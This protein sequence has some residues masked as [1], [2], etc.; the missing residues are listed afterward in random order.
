MK[1]APSCLCLGLSI[2]CLISVRSTYAAEVD[3]KKLPLPAPRKVDFVKDI[4]PIFDEKCISCHGPKKQ[5]GKYRMDTKEGAFKKTDA[6]M[7]I[8]TGN[9]EKS[10]LVHM[11]AGLIEES[12]M[13][14]PSDKPG[15]S[16]PLTKEQISLLRAWID[17]GAEWPDGP[18][19]LAAKPVTFAEDIA[20][21]FQQACAS[22]HGAAKAEGG[23]RVD[24]R[25]A[26][27]KGGAGYG[28]AVKPGD[29]KSPLVIIA[30]G[31]DGDIPQPEKH[32]LPAKQLDLL[33]KWIEQ[34]AK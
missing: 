3:T 15:E 26:V 31:Q 11:V 9:S 23:F 4:Y 27:L 1:S 34:G 7:F 29:L 8:I 28:A 25:E 21:M 32:K 12:L 5:K 24:S 2:L 14:P 18:I 13:P 30:S 22:C 6:G 33:K 16:E 19:A 10:P 20:P 17:Q